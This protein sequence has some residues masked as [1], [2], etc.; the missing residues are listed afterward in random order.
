MKNLLIVTFLTLV[1]FVLSSAQD[2]SSFYAI[3]GFTLPA[4]HEGQYSLSFSP[5]Y[6]Y[7]PTYQSGSEFKN[8]YQYIDN[9]NGKTSF[10]TLGLTGLYGLSDQTT[11]EL[12]FTGG[13]R[14]STPTSMYTE[15]YPSYSGKDIYQYNGTENMDQFSTSLT[16]AHRVTH[17]I[18]LSA[19]ASYF[20]YNQP[21]SQTDIHSSFN[22]QFPTTTDQS[23]SSYKSRSLNIVLN[24][25]LLSN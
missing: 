19:S 6:N 4:L 3:S 15:F 1:T 22:N 20:N 11:L 7:N 8:T 16:I 5:A 2:Y 10:F 21:Q 17:F 23:V 12:A 14:Q 13:P 24:F 25:T 9:G 18:E